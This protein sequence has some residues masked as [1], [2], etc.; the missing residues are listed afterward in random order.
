MIFSTSSAEKPK[1]EEIP[2][3]EDVPIPRKRRSVNSI[4]YYVSILLIGLGLGFTIGFYC[5]TNSSP[6]SHPIPTAPATAPATPLPH[7]VFAPRVPK[8]F[9]PDE[10]Y[11]GYS[12]EVNENWGLLVKGMYHKATVIVSILTLWFFRRRHNLPRKS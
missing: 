7:D 12:H 8:L 2:E 11:V 10:R 3:N 6:T 4:L 9:V 1:Y 5:Q